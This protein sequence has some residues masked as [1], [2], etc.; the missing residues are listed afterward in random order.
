MRLAILI[1]AGNR[2]DEFALDTLHA[3]RRAAWALREMGGRNLTNNFEI[4]STHGE[5]DLESGPFRRRI[6]Q[7]PPTIRPIEGGGA[8]YGAM[9]GSRYIY[10]I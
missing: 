1:V 9:G 2:R 3:P 6:K 4:T 10:I 5:G 8:P 7:K